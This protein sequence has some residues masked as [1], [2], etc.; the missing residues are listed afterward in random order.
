M[1]QKK[2]DLTNG[3]NKFFNEFL[4][5]NRLIFAKLKD[6]IN[7][8]Q[9]MLIDSLDDVKRK[10]KLFYYEEDMFSNATSYTS[11]PRNVDMNLRK[12]KKFRIKNIKKIK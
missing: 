9:N 5:T 1:R 8:K 2:V 11:V 12:E 4:D 7:V 10:I 3:I 6:N